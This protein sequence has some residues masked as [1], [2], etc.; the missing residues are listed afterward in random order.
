VENKIA[1]RIEKVQRE[2]KKRKT[3]NLQTKTENAFIKFGMLTGL[4]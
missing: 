4:P 2:A 3:S 1:K